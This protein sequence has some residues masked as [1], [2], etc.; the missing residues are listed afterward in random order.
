MDRYPETVDDIDA[1]WL[2]SVIRDV[3][4]EVVVAGVEIVERHH[5]TNAH[6]RLRVEYAT[7]AGAP[8]ELFVKLPPNDARREAILATRMGPREV[9]FYRA[10]APRLDL[11]VPTLHGGAHDSDG[12]FAL[13][14]EDLTTSGAQVSDGTWGMPPDAVAGALVELA[15][16]H[17]RYF[18]SARRT[19]EAAWVPVLGPGGDYGKVMLRFGIDNH[20]DRLTDAFERVADAYIGHTAALQALWQE[21]PPTVIHGDPHLGNLFLDGERMGFLD[22]GIVNA[23]NPMRDVSY[24]I[25][26]GMDVE[27]RRA[28]ERDLIATYREALAALGGP[29]L[30][31][32]EAWRAHRLQSAY[33][34]PASCQ[35][36][37]FPADA[38]PARR[39][40][41]DAFLARCLAVL[42]DLDVVGALAAE[43]L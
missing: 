22:W 17:A 33:T 4:P 18:D 40:F 41:S 30:D 11:R 6:A 26:M 20:R 29:D 38:T 27:D 13:V 37:T 15:A 32:D 9:D 7:A 10:L 1:E 35:V 31:A 19:A 3:H 5:L 34:V 2:Q 21:G 42:D 16:M 39:V 36:V 43:G 14:L 25:T 23:G 12:R 28:R 24:L 8:P